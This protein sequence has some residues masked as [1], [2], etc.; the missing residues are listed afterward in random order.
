MDSVGA[1]SQRLALARATVD[2]AGAR[3][4]D[5]AWLAVR[6]ADP[7]SLAVRVHGG[8]TPVR[9]GRLVLV[10]TTDAG[11]GTTYFLG[12]DDDD[13]A[14]FGVADQGPDPRGRRRRAARPAHGRRPAGR[15]RRRAARPRDRPGQLARRARLLLAVRARHGRRLG[16]PRTPLPELRD[17]ALPAHRP[18]RHRAGDRPG[19]P[20]AA[21]AQPGLAGGPVLTLAGFVEPGE[22]AEMAVVREIAE[23][24]G[25]A[26]HGRAL[27]RQPAVAVPVVADARLHRARRGPLDPGAGRRGDLRAALVHPRAAAPRPWPPG[28]VLPPGGISIARRLVEHWYGGPLP[29][30]PRASQALEAQSATERRARGPGRGSGWSARCRR[31]TRRSAPSGSRR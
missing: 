18:G 21:R 10:P 4:T 19:R 6:W 17:R 25:V 9:D 7:T 11:L 24:A 22:S 15:P 14:Y 16:R 28:E 1:C 26:R 8:R 5:D 13:V 31:G 20:G 29:E 3:W 2:R 12:V 23:E 27:S 30:P